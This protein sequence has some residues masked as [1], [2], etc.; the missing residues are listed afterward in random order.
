MEQILFWSGIG[1]ISSYYVSSV[2]YFFIDREAP[3]F[4]PITYIGLICGFI[5]G[6]TGKSIY[7]VITS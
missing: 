4:S 2:L 7:D 5:R 1:F 3:L 6:Y